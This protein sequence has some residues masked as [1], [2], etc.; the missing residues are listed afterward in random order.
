MVGV[1]NVSKICAYDVGMESLASALAENSL[2]CPTH[3][4]KGNG[5]ESTKSNGWIFWEKYFI[6]KL[7]YFLYKHCSQRM[8]GT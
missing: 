8:L 4:V 1:M 2:A 3:L 6:L 7:P 5:L